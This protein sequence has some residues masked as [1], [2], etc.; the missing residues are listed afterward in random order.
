M[1]KPFEE[2]VSRKDN[3]RFNFDGQEKRSSKRG[4]SLV[5]FAADLFRSLNPDS[6]RKLKEKSLKHVLGF[7]STILLLTVILM[8]ILNIGQLNSF[9][10]ELNSGLNKFTTIS[11][12]PNISANESFEIS[13]SIPIYF[14]NT[15]KSINLSKISKEGVILTRKEFYINKPCVS[16]LPLYCKFKKQ[17]I[18]NESYENFF[19]IK[20]NQNIT[21]ILKDL[22]YLLL[23]YLFIIVYTF[24][25][26]K[27]SLI[28]LAISIV[29]FVILLSMRRKPSF[30][31]IL[32]MSLFSATIFT[33]SYVSFSET[34][35]LICFAVYCLLFFLGILINYL[36][37]DL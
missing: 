4:I 18:I 2:K 35:K 10:E 16:I 22:I 12:N 36:N 9:P 28:A 29:S 34:T 33:I 32:K 7:F 26:L 27:I 1:K 31:F 17:R 8:F 24:L 21:N 14:N 19:N 23:P 37:V 15:N 25:W 20:D 30:N 3:R 6:Y 11:F 5:R 13:K